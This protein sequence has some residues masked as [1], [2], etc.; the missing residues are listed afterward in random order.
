MVFVHGAGQ[1]VGGAGRFQDEGGQRAVIRGLVRQGNHLPHAVGDAVQGNLGFGP[2]CRHARIARR[3][4]DLQ[5]GLDLRHQRLIGLGILDRVLAERLEFFIV[6]ADAH[7]QAA[8]VVAQAVHPAPDFGARGL[9]R[10][11]TSR[12]EIARAECRQLIG[13]RGARAYLDAFT[14]GRIVSGQ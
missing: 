2:G 10:R 9:P 11:H 8:K 13:F 5:A 4:A 12:C 6:V 1:A 3:G 14:T 7:L